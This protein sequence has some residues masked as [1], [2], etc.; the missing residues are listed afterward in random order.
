MTEWDSTVLVN[1]IDSTYSLSTY[2][3]L[4]D[5]LYTLRITSHDYSENGMVPIIRQFIV[6]NKQ[7]QLGNILPRPGESKL[8]GGHEVSRLENI[9]LFYQE[10]LSIIRDSLHY[11]IQFSQDDTVLQTEFPFPD[12]LKLS[13][14]IDWSEDLSYK[15]SDFNS[16]YISRTQSDTL[17]WSIQLD[18]LLSLLVEN[19]SLISGLER[20]NAKIVF[21]LS[22]YTTNTDADSVE[23]AILLNMN[24]LLGTEVFNYPNPFSVSK[25]EK[26]RIRYV[27]NKEELKKGKFIIFDAGGDVVFY[28]NDINLSVG[29]HDD[30]TWNG[31][32]LRGN[33]LA[34]GI[35][36]GFLEIEN[37][38]PIRIKISII[39]R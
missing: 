29:T 30:L 2:P 13:L 18:S 24:R 32:N 7:P 3:Y 15:N 36:F 25:G 5:D 16:S 39:N 22:D 1:N 26:T 6:D 27:I 9:V 35:Y 8:G 20:M 11:L 34:S 12:S 23:Y 4:Q 28:N 17:N 37:D 31:T 14:R 33:K 10:D 38:K 21:M 19:D